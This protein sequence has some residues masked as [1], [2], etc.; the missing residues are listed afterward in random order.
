MWLLKV[1]RE[2]IF[3]EDLSKEFHNHARQYFEVILNQID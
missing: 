3:F 2:E 1:Q